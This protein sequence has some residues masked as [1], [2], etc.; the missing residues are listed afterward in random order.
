MVK[1]VMFGF[2]DGITVDTAANPAQAGDVIS[3]Y[4]TEEGQTTPVGVDGKFA[5]VSLRRPVLPVTVTIG[6]ENAEIS[7]AG[8]APG[9]VTGL[10]QINARIP[11]GIP[12]GA[13]VPVALRVGNASGQAGVTIAVR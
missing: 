3:L 11:S 5:A 9:A 4:A 1:Y 7:Y 2:Q 6:G 13:V 8:G 12:T 10:M